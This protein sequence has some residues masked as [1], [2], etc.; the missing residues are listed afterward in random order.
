M[1]PCLNLKLKLWIKYRKDAS[2]LLNWFFSGLR[3][4]YINADNF[5]IEHRIWW[6]WQ[7]SKLFSFVE[8]K[9]K[10]KNLFKKNFIRKKNPIFCPDLDPHQMTGKSKHWQ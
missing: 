2:I 1:W 10:A 5:L 3:N 8:L 6:L 9:A 7:S 4:I